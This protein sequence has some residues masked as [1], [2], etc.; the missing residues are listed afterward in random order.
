[1]PF[2]A[3]CLSI[4]LQS[5]QGAQV[6]ANGCIGVVDNVRHLN[7]PL[8]MES[9]EATHHDR[10]SLTVKACKFIDSHSQ[11]STWDNRQWLC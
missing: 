9:D 8:T 4:S 2:Y 7:P 10:R 1:L 11:E 3:I 6:M 5:Q